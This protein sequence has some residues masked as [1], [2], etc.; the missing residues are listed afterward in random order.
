MEVSKYDVSEVLS[1]SRLFY[2][3][4]SKLS[5]LMQL[6]FSIERIFSPFPLYQRLLSIHHST[7]RDHYG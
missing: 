1:S 3:I 5:P 4:H 7:V 6:A 2:Q